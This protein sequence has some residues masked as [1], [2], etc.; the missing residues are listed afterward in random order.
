MIAAWWLV[1]PPADEQKGW[2]I[3]GLLA[4][5]AGVATVLCLDH[6]VRVVL[7]PMVAGLVYMLL[8]RRGG[9]WA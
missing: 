8:A 4:W 1:A 3:T 6:P 5:A 7:G 2:R 9:A